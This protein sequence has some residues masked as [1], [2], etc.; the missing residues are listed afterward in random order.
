MRIVPYDFRPAKFISS[1]SIGYWVRLYLLFDGT[2]TYTFYH[3]SDCI[4]NAALCKELGVVSYSFQHE[5]LVTLDTFPL[6]FN[7]IQNYV[8]SSNHD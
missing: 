7:E 5:I 8:S 6:I 1:R 3:L 4:E 2:T